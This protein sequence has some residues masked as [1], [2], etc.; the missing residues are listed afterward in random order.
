MDKIHDILS[1]WVGAYPIF[2]LALAVLA[3]MSIGALI[4]RKKKK[5]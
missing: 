4:F 2:S 3:G 5:E 1:P